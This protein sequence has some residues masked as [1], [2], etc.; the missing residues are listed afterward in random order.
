MRAQLS[1][2]FSLP[3]PMARDPFLEKTNP[4]DSPPRLEA[5]LQLFRSRYEMVRELGSG[6]MGVVWL[7]RDL[8]LK[9]VERA[10]KFL[11]SARAWDKEDLERLKTEVLAADALA[12]PRL[13]ATKGFEHDPPYAAI[14]MEYV[15]GSTLKQRVAQAPQKFFEPSEIQ[16]WISQIVEALVFLHRDAERLHRD[17]KPANVIVDKAGRTKL[18]DFGISE[19]NRHTISRHSRL[20]DAPAKPSTSHTLAYASPQQVR[21]DAPSEWDDIYGLGALMYE[22]L[23]GCPPFFRGD[24]VMVGLQIQ[25]QVPPTVAARRAELVQERRIPSIGQPIG[26]RWESLVSACLAKEQMHRPTLEEIAAVL[27]GGPLPEVLKR[28]ARRWRPRWP[29]DQKTSA[30]GAAAALGIAG[31]FWLLPDQEPGTDLTSGTDPK[32]A[33]Q[34]SPTP[35][36][37]P[38]P[39]PPPAP[40]GVTRA[41]VEAFAD[42]YYEMGTSPGNPARLAEM[43]ADKV[44][45]FGRSLPKA[46]VLKDSADYH[47]RWPTQ[48]WSV[49]SA[50]A[51]HG[52]KDKIW[53]VTVNFKFD[54]EDDYLRLSGA[55]EGTLTIA[56]TSAG[57]KVTSINA[58]EK[59]PGS[60]TLKT[61]GFR[62]F[63]ARY[64]EACGLDDSTER[65]EWRPWSF[66]AETVNPY[67][68]EVSPKTKRS[69]LSRQDIQALETEAAAKTVQREFGLMPDAEFTVTEA[70]VPNGKTKDSDR[71]YELRYFIRIRIETNDGKPPVAV[72]GRPEYCQVVFNDGKPE[73]VAIGR[74]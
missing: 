29:W 21:G 1:A 41:Q 70:K 42:S 15:D 10:L 7:A 47:L 64:L 66:F 36:P 31:I 57:L 2:A 5:G 59:T 8:E 30:I 72:D 9:G 65:S 17:V 50:S 20:T 18:M 62:Q 71:R 48:R 67:F 49:T 16:S 35:N 38:Q 22:L 44:E 46:D 69:E 43:L 3:F 6:G 11:P 26:D 53:Q 28:R 60:R 45:F 39:Q 68:A 73:I 13:L 63:A 52:P 12:H 51:K 33:P 55:H 37:A 58:K 24:A 27:R 74:R 4:G 32:P 19:E 56:E 25:S 14:V 61:E 54:L 34:P 40:A 23:T